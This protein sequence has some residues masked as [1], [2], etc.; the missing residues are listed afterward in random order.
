MLFFRVFWSIFWRT[1]LV[2]IVNAGVSYAIGMTSH[3]LSYNTT[4]LIK[5]R[6]SLGFFP[7]A[8]IFSILAWR[9]PAFNNGLLRNRS[10]LD[11]KRWRETYFVLAALCFVLIFISFAAAYALETGSWLAVQQ[12]TNPT[13]WLA[14]W[15]GLSI[16]QTSKIKKSLL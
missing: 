13:L 2:L 8:I 5:L 11:A 7:A 4:E 10:P 16:W 15:I 14:T 3:Q 9:S 6:R 12:L 1:V